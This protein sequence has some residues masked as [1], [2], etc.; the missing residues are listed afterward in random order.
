[1]HDP[2]AHA[3]VQAI[4]AACALL[5]ADSLGPVPDAHGLCPAVTIQE[6]NANA[7][8]D[9]DLGADRGGS[10]AGQATQGQGEQGR[11]PP[12]PLG[13]AQVKAQSQVERERGGDTP[14]LH[15]GKYDLYTSCF[16]CPMCF[17]A[18]YWA[19]IK[20]VIYV[21]QPSDAAEAGFADAWLF[22]QLAAPAQKRAVLFERLHG[23]AQ[24]ARAPFDAYRALQ[25]PQAAQGQG[26]GESQGQV[27]GRA[28]QS[29]GAAPQAAGMKVQSQQPLAGG[30]GVT[31][32]ARV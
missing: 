3:E 21:A 2:T 31:G 15:L 4:R 14:E 8:T 7:D 22:H 28:G 23:L 1:M 10:G 32:T 20:R 19:G 27:G 16:P 6:P 29:L 17:A 18:A 12:Q 11:P 13:L 24:E 25:G 5:R 26:A 9:M 30:R